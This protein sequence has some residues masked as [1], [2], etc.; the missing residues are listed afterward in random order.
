MIMLNGDECGSHGRRR[1]EVKFQCNSVNDTTC[2]SEIS[3]PSTCNYVIVL[4]T[5]LAC[6]N[7]ENGWSM[8]VYPYLN[9]SLKAEWD[10]FFTQFQNKLIS[11][12]VFFCLF[13]YFDCFGVIFTNKNVKVV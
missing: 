8:Q 6:E 4:T 11:E 3:E 1:T 5:P 13:S 7:I 2:I 10:L 12:K 9:E